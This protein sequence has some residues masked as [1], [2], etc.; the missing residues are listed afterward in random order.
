MSMPW[1]QFEGLQLPPIEIEDLVA[2]AL[3]H[4]VNVPPFL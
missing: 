2:R 4:F 3:K 1:H